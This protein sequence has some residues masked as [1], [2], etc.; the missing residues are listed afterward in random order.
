MRRIV[1]MAVGGPFARWMWRRGWGG[2]TIPLP[3]VTV[4][5]YW[6]HPDQC[7]DECID[8]CFHE[9]KHAEQAER[10]GWFRWWIAY[11]WWTIRLGYWDNPLEVEAR[12]WWKLPG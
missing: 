6:L 3:W 10:M 9:R 8:I 12:S 4:I 1:E 5:L 2:C 7:V 11:A